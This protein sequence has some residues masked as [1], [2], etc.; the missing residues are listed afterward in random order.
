MPTV[1]LHEDLLALDAAIARLRRMWESPRSRRRFL[2]RLGEDV[3]P[4][5]IRTLRAIEVADDPEPGVRDVAEVLGVD[6]STASRLVDS[7]V[8]AGLAVR[9]TSTRDRR[10]AR[11][12]LSDEGR[13]LRRRTLEV[14]TALLAERTAGWAPEEVA[15]LAT[16]LDRLARSMVADDAG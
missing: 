13:A 11:L 1:A 4:A 10:R 2:A 3:D 7:A 8:S 12:A 15:T 14:R 16:L 9:T 5:L 6:T